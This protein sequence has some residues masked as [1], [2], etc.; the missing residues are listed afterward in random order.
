M[1][2]YR[3]MLLTAAGCLLLRADLPE[4]QFNTEDVVAFIDQVY[5][6]SESFASLSE[7]FSGREATR[8][9]M[10]W[11]SMPEE[12]SGQYLVFLLRQAIAS[13]QI[14]SF[15]VLV[16]MPGDTEPLA[17]TILVDPADYE[18]REVWFG[19]TGKEIE[20][21]ARP[22]SWKVEAI[23]ADGTLVFR[24]NSFL[25]SEQRAGADK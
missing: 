9:R 22:V 20:P 16:Q 6:S 12:R 7:F 18:W 24:S 5:V 15:N 19:I 10:V 25:W 8:G 11:R 3:L 17:H 21:T 23:K 14:E 4:P 13:L 1:Q 2:I